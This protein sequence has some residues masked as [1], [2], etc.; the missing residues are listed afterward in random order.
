MM[1]RRSLL[2]LALG[3]A[4]T[5]LF[6]IDEA[7]PSNIKIAHRINAKAVTDDDLL[8]FQQIG[9]RWARLEFGEAPLSLDQFRA[10]QQRFAKF[11]MAVYSGVHYSYRT[12]P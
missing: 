9:L 8:F 11:G 7:D 3:A 10:T 5:P 2:K 12:T 1:H 6:A 4:A